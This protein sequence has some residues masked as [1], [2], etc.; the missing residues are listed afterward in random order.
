MTEPGLKGVTFIAVNT[1]AQAL[2]MSDADVKLEVGREL[3]RGL[4]AGTEPDVGRKAAEGYIEEIEEMLKGADIVFVM[5]GEGGGT[6]TGAAPI[7][8]ATNLARLQSVWSLSPSPSKAR[9]GLVRPRREWA[10]SGLN[11]LS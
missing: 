6:G 9:S 11:A 4:G 8:L 7:A 1:H 2:L 3:T 10:P 5:A